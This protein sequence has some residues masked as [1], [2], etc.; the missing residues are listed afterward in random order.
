MH[1]AKRAPEGSQEPSFDAENEGGLLVEG[2]RGEKGQV[3]ISE[4]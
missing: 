1:T 3:P 4:S 2:A